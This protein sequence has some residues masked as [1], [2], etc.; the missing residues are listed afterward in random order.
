MEAHGVAGRGR[1]RDRP[2]HRHRRLARHDRARLGDR[3]LAGDLREGQAA[4]I[5]V[6]AGPIWL[7]DNSSVMKQVHERLYGGS[8]LL[9]DAGPVPLLRPGRRLPDHRQRGRHQALRAQRALHAAAHRL[10]DPAAGRR[11]LDRRGRARAVVPR[12]RLGW[13]GERL[14]QPQ[15]HLHDLEPDA[16]GADAQGRGRHPGVRQPALASGTPAAASTSRTPST[17]DRALRSGRGSRR[18]PTT[19]SSAGVRSG[20][21]A[22]FAAAAERLVTIDAAARS[23]LRLHGSLRRGGRPG[24]LARRHPGHR[25]LRGTLVA[26]HLGLPDPGQHREEARRPREPHGAVEQPRRRD[27]DR[28]PTVDPALFR[29]ADDQ[30]PGGWRSLPAEWRS[31]EGSVLDGEVRT[32]VRGGD[33]RAARPAADRDHP[34]RRAGSQLRR[35]VPRCSSCPGPTSA[36]CCTAP[37]PLYAPRLASYLEVAR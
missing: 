36:C 4:D 26:A 14:H 13:P 19:R 16:P 28:G 25:R 2:R 33:R 37:A 11:R 29:D 23:H 32:T 20:D 3:R 1:P 24:H 31:A 35:G 22:V 15:H 21:E 34:A 27:E 5:L 7:G 30:Y 17:G 9:N 12:P 10:H 8:H 6:L 18:A